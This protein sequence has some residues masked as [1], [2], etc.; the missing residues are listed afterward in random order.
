M[1]YDQARQCVVLFDGTDTWEYGYPGFLSLAGSPRPH[2]TVSLALSARTNAERPYVLGT[3]LGIGPIPIGSRT[4]GPS[5]DALLVTSV[6]CSW[7]RFFEGYA[8]RIDA[9]GTATAKLH[10]PPLAAL[11][12]LRLPPP[13]GCA[14]RC[15]REPILAR[16]LEDRRG[17]PV[18][19]NVPHLATVVVHPKERRR[20]C[21]L[22]PLR[23]RPGLRFVDFEHGVSIDASGHVVLEIGAPLLT[24]ADG[25]A[26]LLVLD[27]TWRL[28]PELRHALV[29]GFVCRSLPRALRTV[30]PRR[31]RGG[32]D[33]PEGLASV[34]ALFA[35]RCLLGARDDALLAGYRWKQEFLAA[36]ARAG[37]L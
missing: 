18:N 28:L 31:A 34:E 36:C 20:K 11:V 27:A 10:V 16:A 15:G 12:G 2:G 30:Y 19:T 32:G 1:V 23:G 8:G 35:A 21:S 26:P 7:P 9:G 6:G 37:V 33:P 5:A 4:L 17:R 29:G 3:A 24:P 14:R 22:E 25:G 13:R